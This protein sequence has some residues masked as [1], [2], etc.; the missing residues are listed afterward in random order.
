MN[1]VVWPADRDRLAILQAILSQAE[2]PCRIVLTAEALVGSVSAFPDGALPL[3]DVCDLPDAMQRCVSV[4]RQTEVLLHIIHRR[5]GLLTHHIAHVA[6]GPLI[7]LEPESVGFPLIAYFRLL[8]ATSSL[9]WPSE[10]PCIAM[11]SARERQVL[12]LCADGLSR[13]Q[14][15]RRLGITS[16]TVRSHLAA[17]AG[18]LGAGTC[19]EAVSTYKRLLDCLPVDRRIAP[20]LP[21]LS[22]GQVDAGSGMVSLREAAGPAAMHHLV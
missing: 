9:S 14:I 1:V 20:K 18:H 5:D 4:A 12:Q 15:A 7:W 22:D 21:G 10:Q 11:L 19:A 17:A 3:L 13:K 16:S 2:I 6:R 8:K